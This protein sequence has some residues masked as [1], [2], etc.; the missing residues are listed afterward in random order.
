MADD[1][2]RTA[3][4]TEKVIAKVES[5]RAA[6]IVLVLVTAVWVAQAVVTIIEKR[7]KPRIKTNK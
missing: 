5:V 7:G 6:V 1:T 3:A 4:V 2:M